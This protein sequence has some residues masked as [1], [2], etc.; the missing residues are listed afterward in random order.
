IARDPADAEAIA[1]LSAL[2]QWNAQLRTTCVATMLSGGHAENAL[3]QSAAAVVNCRVQPVDDPAEV[4][5]TLA[6][7]VADPEIRISVMTPAKP[8][9]Y[10]PLNPLVLGA[11]T[12]A[13][14]KLWPGLPVI[15]EMSAGASDSIYLLAGGIPAYGV[16]GIFTDEDD[17]RAHGKDE[18]IAVKSFYEALDFEDALVREVAR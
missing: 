5:T 7:V 11:I 15:P 4:E 1:G 17:V 10:L 3:P 13:T 12:R 18:R 16:S 8:A 9:R 2:P 6:R 14:E